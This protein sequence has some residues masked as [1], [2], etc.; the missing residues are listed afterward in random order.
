M[1]SWTWFQGVWN[2]IWVG[3]HEG[4]VLVP[5]NQA[6]HSGPSGFQCNNVGPN[7]LGF[8]GLGVGVGGIIL[9]KQLS[10][11]KL[12][13]F[14]FFFFF[15]FWPHAEVPR[16]GIEPKPQQWQCQIVSP[17]SHQG[18]PWKGGFFFF[19]FYGCTCSLWKFPGWESN[20]IC[21]CRPTPQPQRRQLRG[22]IC[23]LHHSLWQ[24]WIF[25]PLNEARNWTLIL[26]ATSQVL[27]PRSHKG[28]SKPEAFW[29][30]PGKDLGTRTRTRRKKKN[31]WY[32]TYALGSS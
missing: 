3:R 27:N 19:N 5:R 23:N 6:T 11:W 9:E 32:S 10:G 24:C 13:L 16:P 4:A 15:F 21:S 8:L 31:M 14:L 20:Q 26:M 17:L 18:T 1:S 7:S 29:T 2:R 28:N 25:N 30:A 22:L 12:R